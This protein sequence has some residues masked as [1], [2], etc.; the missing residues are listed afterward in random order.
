MAFEGAEADRFGIVSKDLG[1]VTEF[2]KSY[3][4]NLGAG[5]FTSLEGKG[6][7][8]KRKPIAEGKVLLQFEIKEFKTQQDIW[9]I[10]REID[11]WNEKGFIDMSD[12]DDG[13]KKKK[14]IDGVECGECKAVMI[15]NAKFCSDCGNKLVSQNTNPG[16]ERKAA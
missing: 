8:C 4:L 16:I 15:L 10:I 3:G 14:I 2:V 9:K 11:K 12:I 5:H 13:P 1:E 7:F 6:L